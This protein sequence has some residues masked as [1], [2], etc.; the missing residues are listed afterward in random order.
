MARC[1]MMC[2]IKKW[3]KSAAGVVS[4]ILFVTSIIL[5]GA[6]CSDYGNFSERTTNNVN[7]IL[8]GLATNLL[9]IIVTVSFVQ[10]FVDRQNEKDEHRE[11]NL[12]IKRYDRF[13]NILLTRYL[14]YLNCVTT[15]IE[16]RSKNNPLRLSFQFEFEDM[17]DLHK[18][19]LYTCEG[20]F[21][22]SIELFYKS[23]EKLRNYMIEMIQNIDFKYNDQLKEI[24]IQFVE[25]SIEYDMRGAILG[26]ITT[27]S[28]GK[29]MTETIMEYI[30][31][32][33]HDWV[34]KGQKGEL[35]SN[36]M[37]PYVQLYSLLKIE[38][39]LIGN[40]KNCIANIE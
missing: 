20:I 34:G 19:S 14:M 21:E 28:S 12:K 24:I 5:L 15:P 13:M 1:Y 8:I 36:M 35:N 39:E 16:R 23:E 11:E 10:H 17:C 29:Q 31:D 3:I 4:I 26:N 32:T 38:I 2:K 22:S 25:K 27:Y 9:G 6:A 33:S 7:N 37:L 18:Q 30:K 40:Y